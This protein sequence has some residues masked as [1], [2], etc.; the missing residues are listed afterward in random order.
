MGCMDFWGV[1]IFVV[2]CNFLVAFLWASGGTG[3][4]PGGPGDAPGGPESQIRLTRMLKRGEYASYVKNS[5]K[6][7]PHLEL[8]TPPC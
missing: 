1:W 7:N 6:H 8:I 4:G 3:G 5:Q 2:F